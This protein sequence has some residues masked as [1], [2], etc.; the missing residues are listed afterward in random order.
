[1]GERVGGVAGSGGRGR[2]GYDRETLLRVCVGV[3][4][5]HGY[6]ATSMGA[7][8]KHLNISKSAIY[9]H[10]SSK[11]EILEL[12]VG[13]AL[14]LLEGV[15]DQCAELEKTPVEK[16]EFFLR[17]TVRLVV[18]ELP[19]VTLLLRLRGNSEVELAALDR[20][21]ELTRFLADLVR[22]AQEAGEIRSDLSPYLVPRLLFGM[23]NSVVEW[24]RPEGPE[25]L[26]SLQECIIELAFGGLRAQRIERR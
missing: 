24:F 7:L 15:R 18:E 4:N 9:H 21:R 17:E 16:I 8:S 25:T 26:E 2:P 10:V 20:R 1:M 11:E 19:Y 12:G 22:E 6:D 13:R 5:R 14:S 3:F 23:S